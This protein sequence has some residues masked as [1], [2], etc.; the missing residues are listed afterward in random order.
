MHILFLVLLAI[1]LITGLF[2]FWHAVFHGMDTDL[3]QSDSQYNW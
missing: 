2:T 1:L 3:S